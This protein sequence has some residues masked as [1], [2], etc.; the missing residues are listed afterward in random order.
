[1]FFLS[2]RE[3]GTRQIV[4]Y[5]LLKGLTNAAHSDVKKMAVKTKMVMAMAWAF[6]Q[7]AMCPCSYRSR[8]LAP[9]YNPCRLSPEKQQIREEFSKYILVWD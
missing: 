9:E 7:E 5:S 3:S 4:L 2:F 1:M 6:V 8:L